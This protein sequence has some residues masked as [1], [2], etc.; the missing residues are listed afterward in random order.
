MNNAASVCCSELK[1]QANRHRLAAERAEVIH[2]DP[3]L[4]AADA[5]P[6]GPQE[7]LVGIKMIDHRQ[8]RQILFPLD[9]FDDGLR[10]FFGSIGAADVALHRLAADVEMNR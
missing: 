5:C 1:L 4:V 2:L 9:G 3:D 10:H 6:G 7:Y 8:H